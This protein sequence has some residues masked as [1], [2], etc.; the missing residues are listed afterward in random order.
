MRHTLACGPVAVQLT[1]SP[2]SIDVTRGRRTVV[3]NLPVGG[4]R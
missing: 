4:G 2:L 3:R 1:P